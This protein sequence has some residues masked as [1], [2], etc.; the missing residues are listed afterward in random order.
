MEYDY[1]WIWSWCIDENHF[2][3]VGYGKWRYQP[4]RPQIR[5]VYLPCF[6]QSCL[7]YRPDLIHLCLVID[8]K[9]IWTWLHSIG[10][11][12]IIIIAC[13]SL[14]WKTKCSAPRSPAMFH[15]MWLDIRDN[16]ALTSHKIQCDTPSIKTMMYFGL[17]C[18]RKCIRPY[19]SP[20]R[21]LARH[22]LMTCWH[23][24]WSMHITG[25]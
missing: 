19:W 10:I 8:Q 24:P 17:I 9:Y 14:Q 22:C 20:I 2:D 1:E 16:T 7:Y 18:A 23:D 25:R 5:V 15:H 3:R 21:C 12:V 11:Y 13:R 6:E 4:D